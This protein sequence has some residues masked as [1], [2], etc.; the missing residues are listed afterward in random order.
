[1]SRHRLAVFV[2]GNGSNLQNIIDHC[3]TNRISAEVA[4]VVT[5]RPDCYAIERANVHQIPTLFTKD[6]VN[7]ALAL[8]LQEH[9]IDLVVLAGFLSKIGN[10]LLDAFPNRV[11]NIHPSLLPKYG[12]KGMYGHHVHQ[13]VL[14][15]QEKITGVT[16]HYVNAHYDEGDIIR[17]ERCNVYRWMDQE[18]IEKAV[19]LLEYHLY[20]EVIRQFL[21]TLEP[22]RSER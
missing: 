18:D 3:E 12:G 8:T 11:I 2:S 7:E 20:P 4:L 21:K 9:K 5:D 13:A 15:N 1:M 6:F 14:A 22:T 17:Q 10:P 19:H 16:V